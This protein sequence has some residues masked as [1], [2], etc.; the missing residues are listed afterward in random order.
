MPMNPRPSITDL[1]RSMNATRAEAEALVA[2]GQ[3]SSALVL[4]NEADMDQAL[5]LARLG[6]L[7]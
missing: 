6:D 4:S 5:I 3:E 7:Y 1:A 2:E